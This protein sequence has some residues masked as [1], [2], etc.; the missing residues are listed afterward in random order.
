[1]YLL[2]YQLIIGLTLEAT[3]PLKHLFIEEDLCYQVK[4]FVIK[5]IISDSNRSIHSSEQ[6]KM[7][8]EIKIQSSE[9]F[10]IFM[11]IKFPKGTNDTR[12]GHS[13]E[14]P[15]GGVQ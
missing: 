8:M 13:T 1:M 3:D 9:Q 10:K 6:F 11:E 15:T 14:R 12:R 7:F 4:V 5:I 2:Y